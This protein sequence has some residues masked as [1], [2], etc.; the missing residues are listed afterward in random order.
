M[1]LREHLQLA[2]FALLGEVFSVFRYEVEVVLGEVDELA[3]REGLDTL[4]GVGGW[5]SRV[6]VV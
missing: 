1:L 5:I 4:L 6:L 2:E 3:A